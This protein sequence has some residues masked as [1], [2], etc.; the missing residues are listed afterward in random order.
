MIFFFFSSVR[1]GGGFKTLQESLAKMLDRAL[2]GFRPSLHLASLVSSSFDGSLDAS[3]ELSPTTS[4]SSSSSSS[5]RSTLDKVLYAKVV[6]N[7]NMEVQK[8]LA[9]ARKNVCAC[10]P[11]HFHLGLL[12][13]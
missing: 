9:H 13:S 4:T 2:G 6:N 12:D 11:C 1:T 8:A 10:S 5:P 7:F 3:V